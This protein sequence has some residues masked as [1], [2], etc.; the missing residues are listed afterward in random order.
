MLAGVAPM[1]DPTVVACQPRLLWA[2]ALPVK[3]APRPA[4]LCPLTR[5]LAT[6]CMHV[7]FVY[8]ISPS[9]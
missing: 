8:D 7:R 4:L 5:G 3:D 1:G 2:V 9:T 6:D